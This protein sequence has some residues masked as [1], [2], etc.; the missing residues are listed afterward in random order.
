MDV[1]RSSSP[2]HDFNESVLLK[3]SVNV[4]VASS[5]LSSRVS[6][7][8]AEMNRSVRFSWVKGWRGAGGKGFLLLCRSSSSAVRVAP[9]VMRIGVRCVFSIGHSFQGSKSPGLG[10]GFCLG[11]YGGWWQ[12]L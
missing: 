9:P 1:P 11:I 2:Q 6:S 5:R 10:R 7:G 12:P 3:V 4:A 8:M